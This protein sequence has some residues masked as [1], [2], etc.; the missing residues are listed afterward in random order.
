MWNRKS[1]WKKVSPQYGLLFSGH[2]L[3]ILF[4]DSWSVLNVYNYW[5]FQVKVAILKY[6]ESLARQMDPT[7]FINSS[8][9]RLAVSRIITWTTEPKSSDVR[10]VRSRELQCTFNDR[11]FLA[12]VQ[13]KEIYLETCKSLSHLFCENQDFA[14]VPYLLSPTLPHSSPWMLNWKS[15][16]SYDGF[17]VF[18]DSYSCF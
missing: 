6:I 18:L 9:T 12:C 5:I 3:R 2:Q 1:R 10:K 8:E 16:I 11:L 13:K 4:K 7:D 15:E 14:H 17:M